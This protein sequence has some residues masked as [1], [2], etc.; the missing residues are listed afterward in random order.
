M[1]DIAA[2]IKSTR[3]THWVKNLAVFAALFFSGN[4]FSHDLFVRTVWA[5]ILFS[6]A[7]S[8]CYLFNDVVDKQRDKRHPV[9]QKRPI[10]KG[11]VPVPFALFVAALLAVI[12]LFLASF[13]SFFL[14]AAIL[15]YILLQISYTLFLKYIEVIDIMAIAGGF[16][17]RVWAGAFVADIHMSVWFLLCVISVALF[18]AAGKRKAELSIIETHGRTLRT[19]YNHSQL[20][21]YLSMFAATS[22]LSWALFTFFEPS[23]QVGTYLPFFTDLPLTLGGI[24]KWLM[25]TIPVVI[26]GV[27]RYL[28]LVYS[29]T[30]EA[31]T[32]ERALINDRPLLLSFVVWAGLVFIIIYSGHG[33]RTLVL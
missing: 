17:L 6:F 10:A 33:E 21:S 19:F 27:M 13:L 31:E 5:A 20:N 12:S 29:K 11:I 7:A 3:P 26:F 16:I 32:P 9:K 30:Q 24:G 18:L 23:P 1:A 2:I 8:S 15:S 4:L 14:F 28:H 25:I 22:W